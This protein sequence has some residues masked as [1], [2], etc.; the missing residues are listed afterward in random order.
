MNQPGVMLDG[1]LISRNITSPPLHVHLTHSLKCLSPFV[2]L[3][4]VTHTRV[5]LCVFASVAH[6]ESHVPVCVHPQL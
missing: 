2:S 4:C 5:F 1:E 3:A 6:A